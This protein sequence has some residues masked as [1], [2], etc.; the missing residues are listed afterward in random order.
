M[1][2]DILGSDIIEDD[3]VI[4]KCAGGCGRTVVYDMTQLRKL[5]MD[6]KITWTC[7]EC[8]GIKNPVHMYQG[9]W[10][11]WDEVW[12]DRIGPFDTEKEADSDCIRYAEYLDTGQ[13]LKT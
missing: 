8:C 3:T 11:Y 10:Y 6:V 4:L 2:E 9:K 13:C 12:A 7:P 5:D 1:F